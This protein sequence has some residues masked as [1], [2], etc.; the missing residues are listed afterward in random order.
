MG[1]TMRYGGK[2]GIGVSV[3]FGNLLAKIEKAG[4]DVEAATWDAARKG[5]KVLYDQMQAECAASGV[6]AS[7]SDA[8]TMQAERSQ[9]GNRYA[10]KVGWRMGEYDPKNP[11]VAYKAIFLNYGTPRRATEGGANRGYIDGKGFMG[12]AK[13]KAR[14]KVKRIQEDTLRGIIEELDKA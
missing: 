9:S 11:S 4:G 12:R 5:A 2:G 10:C 1:K 14:P 6:P 3:N 7:I 8:I 13:K